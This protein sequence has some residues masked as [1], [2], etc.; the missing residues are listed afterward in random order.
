MRVAVAV[1]GTL[2]AEKT[3]DAGTDVTIGTG[4]NA[5]LEVPGWRGP[6]VL[7]ISAG[8][9]LN[10]S[11][12]M[13]LHMCD[14]A[15]DHRVV[16]TFDELAAMGLTFPLEVPVSRL[17]IAVQQGLSVFVVFVEPRI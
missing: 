2:V 3:F 6:N 16:G 1:E 10:L 4:P 8:V 15:G 7:L 13:R 9:L 14:E 12:G 17:N 11:P 5:G